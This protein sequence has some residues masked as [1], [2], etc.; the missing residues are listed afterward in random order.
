MEYLNDFDKVV[1]QGINGAV[2]ALIALDSKEYNSDL[3][4]KYLEFILEKQ[5]ADGGFGLSDDSDIDVTAMTLQ[6]LANYSDDENVQ[7]VIRKAL[8]YLDVQNIVT[9]ESASQAVKDMPLRQ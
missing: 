4:A 6:A 9:S 8:Q 7:N 3:R 5:H 1:S 2:Y